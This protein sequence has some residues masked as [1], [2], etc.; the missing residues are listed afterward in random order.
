M[1]F[2][3]RFPFKV[4][5]E[6]HWQSSSSHQL[7]ADQ[8]DQHKWRSSPG[9]N[10]QIQIQLNFMQS[11]LIVIFLWYHLNVITIIVN[12]ITFEDIVTHWATLTSHHPSKM[13]QRQCWLS[14]RALA[15]WGP[16][17]TASASLGTYLPPSQANFTHLVKLYHFVRQLATSR[18][19][20]KA[21][22]VRANW[23]ETCGKQW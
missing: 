3:Q 20:C 9:K 8:L 2:E 14:D 5:N 17:C 11:H 23:K 19:N 12:V 16:R 18:S 7:A 10:Q 13:L 21:L 15:W 22:K 4:K 1:F 6:P